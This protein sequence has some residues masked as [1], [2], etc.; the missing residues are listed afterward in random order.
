ML[1][2]QQ[3]PN[4]FV[5]VEHSAV[6]GFWDSI[7]IKPELPREKPRHLGLKRCLGHLD[8]RAFGHAVPSALYDDVKGLE[9]VGELRDTCC[10]EV[11]ALNLDSQGFYLV[12]ALFL[13]WSRGG[14][15]F[16]S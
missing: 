2:P 9:D 16:G 15:G 5:V 13:C 6:V 8:L 4:K 11:A 14:K 7:E 3:L 12:D 10:D 1:L